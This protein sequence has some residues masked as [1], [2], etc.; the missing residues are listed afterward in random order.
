MTTR[1]DGFAGL[2]VVPDHAETDDDV[3]DLRAAGCREAIVSFLREMADR[4]EGDDSE[5]VWIDRPLTAVLVLLGADDAC[6]STAGDMTGGI[7]DLVDA[8]QCVL[9]FTSPDDIVTRQERVANTR[10]WRV[11]ERRNKAAARAQFERDHPYLCGCGKRC[12]S[13]SG[14][15]G[16]KTSTGH[17]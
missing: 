8:S 11:D 1:R 17:Q 16:H 5:L 4:I 15:A 13:S 3:S 7:D 14:L 12:K 6:V 2:S 10:S 9:A